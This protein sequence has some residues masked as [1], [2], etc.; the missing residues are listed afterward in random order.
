MSFLPAS[1]YLNPAYYCA[2]FKVPSGGAMTFSF[3]SILLSLFTA[4]IAGLGSY[5]GFYIKGKAE[6]RA[7]TESLKEY[8]ANQVA[9]TKAIEIE[10]LEVATRG[11]LATETRACI[12]SLVAAVQSLVHSMCWLGWDVYHRNKLRQSLAEQYDAEAHKVQ[13]EIMAQQAR[14]S[15]LDAKLFRDTSELI[16]KL[17]VLDAQFAEAIVLAETDEP[18]ALARISELYAESLALQQNLLEAFAGETA[19]NMR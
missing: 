13:A 5:F 12:Y 1:L 18:A 10:K 8:V 17:F 15:R 19:K 16:A 14:L 6:L 3:E 4:L 9:L 7:A 11:A 2:A